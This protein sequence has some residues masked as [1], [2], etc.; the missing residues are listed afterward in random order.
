MMRTAIHNLFSSARNTEDEDGIFGS[1]GSMPMASDSC[2]GCG[3][4]VGNCP[5]RAISM[6]GGSWKVDLGRCIFCM[7]CTMVCPD[8]AIDEVPSPD[9]ALRRE[10]LV[11]GRDHDID[12][13]EGVLDKDTCRRFGRSLAIRELDTGSCN[14]CESELNCMSNQFYDCHRFGIKYVASPRHADAL[15]VTGPMTR[16]MLEASVKTEAAMP[17]PSLIIASGTCAISG[18]VFVGGDEV[19]GSVGSVLE[20]DIYIIGCPPSPDRVIRSLMKALGRH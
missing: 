1:R 7:D 16:N 4:C 11:I 12:G 5:T 14:I 15:I 13:I 2:S 3:K 10:D 8:S 9:Y 17:D 19:D 18:G 20:P 6:D